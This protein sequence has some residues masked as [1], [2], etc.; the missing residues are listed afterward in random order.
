MTEALLL[1]TMCLGQFRSAVEQ[2]IAVRGGVMLLPLVNTEGDRTEELPSHLRLTMDDGAALEGAVVM[3]ALRPDDRIPF[4][5]QVDSFTD[6]MWPHEAP[7][8]QRAQAQLYLLVPLPET[9]DGLLLLGEQKLAPRWAGPFRAHR[10]AAAVAQANDVHTDTPDALAPSERFRWDLLVE[11]SGVIEPPLSE[12]EPTRLLAQHFASLWAMGLARIREGDA[13]V[14]DDLCARLAGVARGTTSDGVNRS[15][16]AWEM[17]RSE[18]DA[19]LEISLSPQVDAAG[20]ARGAEAWMRSR[21]AVMAWVD[22]ESSTEVVIALANPSLNAQTVQLEW[23]GGPT[24]DGTARTIPV[25][26]GELRLARMQ[27]SANSTGI[28]SALAVS[29]TTLA[30]RLVVGSGLYPVRPPGLAFGVFLPTMRL[31]DAQRGAIAPPPLDEQTTAS[32]RHRPH[33]WELFIDCLRSDPPPATDR[34]HISL[35]A[36]PT[37]S[38]DLTPEGH[39]FAQSDSAIDVLPVAHSSGGPGWWRVRLEIPREL[40][41]VD[42]PLLVGVQRTV[43][44][45]RQSAGTPLPP[46]RLLPAPAALDI[47]AWGIVV[48]ES[49]AAP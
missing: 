20:A 49:P 6:A 17:R 9:A 25:G 33:G 40:L 26:P 31:V 35:G 36:I 46:W 41:P 15:L 22:D 19:L 1:A 11:Q 18:L 32:L 43:N 34:V 13:A 7:E 27:R 21:P 23:I 14:A 4:W 24:G 16:A 44:G 45:F 5:T 3:L 30:G 39:V 48:P 10:A 28:A 47:G 29:P 38:F 12:R 42:S 37:V 8:D 2:P